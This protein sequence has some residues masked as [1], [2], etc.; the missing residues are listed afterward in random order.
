MGRKQHSRSKQQA[1][2]AVGP[3]ATS[4]VP[5]SIPRDDIA[6][7]AHAIWIQEGCLIGHQ[8]THWF[9]AENEL[10]LELAQ[11]KNN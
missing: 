11:R 7:R 5:Q 2:Q 9:R 3:A 6:A 10:R 8:A 1:Q 4:E